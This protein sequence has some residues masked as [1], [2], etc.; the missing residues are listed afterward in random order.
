MIRVFQAFILCV[1]FSP[2][3][4]VQASDMNMNS[5]RSPRVHQNRNDFSDRMN[6][7]SSEEFQT[8]QGQEQIFNYGPGVNNGTGTGSGGNNYKTRP[9]QESHRAKN[10]SSNLYSDKLKHEEKNRYLKILLYFL[11]TQLN[12][13]MVKFQNLFS[14]LTEERLQLIGE[15]PFVDDEEF[16]QLSKQSLEND[17]EMMTILMIEASDQFNFT[18]PDNQLLLQL[19][20]KLN[21]EFKKSVLVKNIGI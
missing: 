14:L 5:Y 8:N 17:F 15:N 6:R 11:N 9:Y 3:I 13:D 18:E 19:L 16:I 10:Y 4:K 1:L 12:K 7:R 2:I 21:G 20:F